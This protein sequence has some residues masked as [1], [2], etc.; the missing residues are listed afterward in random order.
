M[1]SAMISSRSQTFLDAFMSDARLVITKFF[2]LDEFVNLA[3]VCKATAG[4]VS[5]RTINKDER[6]RIFARF[7]VEPMLATLKPIKPSSRMWFMQEVDQ[8]AHDAKRAEEKETLRVKHDAWCKLPIFERARTW[9]ETNK[10]LTT[11]PTHD[12][13]RTLFQVTYSSLVKCK[14][15]GSVGGWAVR[16]LVEFMNE[17]IDT[18][19]AASK[20]SYDSAPTHVNHGSVIVRV[21]W[22]NKQYPSW[23][24][25]LLTTPSADTVRQILRDLHNHMLGFLN[26]QKN[27]YTP[28]MAPFHLVAEQFCSAKGRFIDV[29]KKMGKKHWD[30]LSRTNSYVYEL[31]KI[32]DQYNAHRTSQFEAELLIPRILSVRRGDT[33]LSDGDLD[34]ILQILQRNRSSNK[35]RRLD[36]DEDDGVSVGAGADADDFVEADAIILH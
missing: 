34:M 32:Y 4:V 31:R 35:R 2:K 25:Y 11:T 17:P 6:Q 16:P 21:N 23:V 18:N 10:A 12:Y 36:V 5:G 13:Y 24:Q 7:V 14:Y 1:A 19:G 29:T 28:L 8:E 15:D 20:E 30:T 27:P 3:L 22:Y 9:S 33:A 26:H